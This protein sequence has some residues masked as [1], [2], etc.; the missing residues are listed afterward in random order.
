MSNLCIIKILFEQMSQEVSGLLSQAGA[1]QGFWPAVV[2]L[3]V[4]APLAQQAL[5]P[6]GE[7]SV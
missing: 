4:S 6:W 7:G 3:G 1:E 2:E 5:P